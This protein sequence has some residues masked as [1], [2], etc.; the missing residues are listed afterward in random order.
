MVTAIF[1]IVM[2]STLTLLIQNL[3]SKGIHNTTSQY[4]KEQAILLARSYTELAILYASSYDRTID[5]LNTINGQFGPTIING[6]YNIVMELRYIGKDTQFNTNAVPSCYD[7]ATAQPLNARTTLL[8]RLNGGDTFDE[9]ISI[10]IDT[11]VIY[12]DFD[13][14]SAPVA[15]GDRNITVHRRTLQKI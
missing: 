2:M 14:P 8:E 15:D 13:D 1:V 11:Y 5:C 10:I 3:T 6:G 9:S 4:R 7:S 12:K